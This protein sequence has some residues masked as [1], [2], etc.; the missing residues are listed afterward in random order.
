MLQLAMGGRQ[1]RAARSLV[2]AA[3]LH[4]DQTVLQ[5]VDAA[6]AMLAA[7][8]VERFYKLQ[9]SESLPVDAGRPAFFEANNDVGGSVRRLLGRDSQGV[10]ILGRLMPRV[11]ER[12][13]LVRKVPKV[14]V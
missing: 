6:D 9:K 5:Q 10:G 1:N 13:A 3:A 7:D 4:A 12:A 8:L 11:F 14:A 2:D